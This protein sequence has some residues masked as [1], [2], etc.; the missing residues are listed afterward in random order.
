MTSL[1]KRI[2]VDVI[3]DDLILDLA[4]VAQSCPNSL[5][6][7][8][9]YPARLLCPWDSLG[10]NTGVGSFPSPGDLPNPGIKPT[11]PALQADSLLSEPPGKLSGFRVDPKFKERCSH[12]KTQRNP[13]ASVVRA[14]SFHCRRQGFLV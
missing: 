5:R 11:F 13:L 14:L 3:K 7:H 10:K 6:P 4:L 9:L 12:R 1:G 8:G 2:F